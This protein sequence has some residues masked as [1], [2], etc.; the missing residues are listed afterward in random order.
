MDIKKGDS[1]LNIMLISIIIVIVVSIGI[2]S[3]K[4]N[5][6]NINNGG[7]LNKNNENQQEILLSKGDI[8][9]KEE[10]SIRIEIQKLQEILN[11]ELFILVNQNNKLEADYEPSTLVKA[12]IPFEDYI[13]CKKL[14]KRTNEAV[15]KMFDD[16][17]KQNIN[18]IAVS[19]YRSY[20]VQ[21]NLYNSRIELKGLEKTRQYTAEPG[22]SE[23][24][25][26]LAID[27]AETDYPYLDEGFENTDTFKWLV[28]NCYKYG[29][30]LRYQKG[31]E[32]ITGYN[33][34]PWHFRYIGDIDIAKEIMERGICFE[35]Y[36]QEVK[37]KIEKLKKS[38]N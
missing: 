29:F 19:G 23:H 22:A 28:N 35:E 38:I 8:S 5:E 9:L 1:T 17:L 2:D 32:N 30:I 10:E 21:E 3:L 13:E 34:E 11:N 37:Y 26:G 25:T 16:A 4:K 20:Y 14:D 18:M 7:K 12:D 6:I 36:I 33:Y 15:M 31:K 24:Q 27:I